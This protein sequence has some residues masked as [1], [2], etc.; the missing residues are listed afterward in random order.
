MHRVVYLIS[1]L[2]VLYLQQFINEGL[3]SDILTSM[4]ITADT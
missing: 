1:S 3:S 2:V 4:E